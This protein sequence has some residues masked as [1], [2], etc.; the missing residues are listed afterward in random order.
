MTRVH[1]VLLLASRLFAVAAL[2]VGGIVTASLYRIRFGRRW[3]LRPQGQQVIQAWMRQVARTVGM[4]ISIN[5]VA[6]DRPALIVANHVSWLDIVALNAVQ[7]MSFLAK[8]SVRAWPL[9]GPLSAMTGTLFLRRGSLSAINRSMD[10]IGW[11][12]RTGHR[13]AIFP[14]GTTTDGTTVRSFHRALFRSAER[15]GVP[16]QPVAIRYV[17]RGVRDRIAPFVG[18]DGFL[19]HLLRVAAAGPMEVQLTWCESIVAAG[20]D[21]RDVALAA[22]ERIANVLDGDMAQALAAV[23][24][25]E[26]YPPCPAD[27]ARSHTAAGRQA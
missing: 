17:R 24:R 11:R 3:F 20:T 23:A 2:I 16:V 6:P 1:A 22:R 12:L 25:V 26:Q 5:G 4:R 19:S 8:D 18:D 15:A 7:A 10:E 13:V 9:L 21:S 27:V 14:E